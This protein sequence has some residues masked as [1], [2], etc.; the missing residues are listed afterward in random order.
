M[1][2]RFACEKCGHPIEVSDRFEGKH[3]KCKHCG[4]HITVPDHVAEAH[5]SPLRLRPVETD[6]PEGIHAHLLAPQ[7]PLKV[8]AAE[9][10]P[11][12]RLEAIT[13]P[14]LPPHSRLGGLLRGRG[15]QDYTV[16][17]ASAASLQHS[18][19]GPAPFWLSYSNQAARFIARIFR[20][21][22]DW[23]YVVSIFFLVLVLVGYL[24]Q[25]SPLLH[26]GATGVIAA[27]IGML[28]VGVAY[29]VSLPFKES[30]F[31]GLANLF[32]PF[33]AIYYWTTRWHKMKVPVF[34]TLGSFVPIMLV[35]L[36][37]LIY[38]ERDEIKKD[39]PG[40]ERAI[41]EKVEALE[42]KVG[43][44]AKAKPEGVVPAPASTDAPGDAPQGAPPL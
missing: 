26:L 21:L 35:G 28:C 10:D 33:Y 1:S 19:T 15:D 13:E 2:I 23:I 9:E 14:D 18:A 36:A 41:E 12:V 37:Y 17:A 11:K 29:L 20:I 27:N 22:R 30:P 32:I 4:H 44:G 6:E 24:F 31:H 39:L 3:G 34:K 5:D 43:G 25:I 16:K 7:A 38:E 40:I 42:G 8:R